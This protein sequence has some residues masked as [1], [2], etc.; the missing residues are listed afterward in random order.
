MK[1]RLQISV[2]VEGESGEVTITRQRGRGRKELKIYRVRTNGDIGSEECIP[3]DTTILIRK[4]VRAAID[5]T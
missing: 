3:L 2:T 5:K 4:A 1:H